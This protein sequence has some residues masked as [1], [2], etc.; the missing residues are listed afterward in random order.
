MFHW[1]CFVWFH[2]LLMLFCLISC[3]TN[4]VL[5]Y[6]MFH[7]CCFVWFHVSLVLF[8][9]ISCFTGVVLFDFMFYWCIY[10]SLVL[11]CLH[12]FHW[13]WFF[14]C[15]ASCVLLVL[16]ICSTGV[17][18]FAAIASILHLFCFVCC[19]SSLMLFGFMFNSLVFFLLHMCCI[20]HSN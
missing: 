19:N 13:H 3:F 18:L 14:L 8:C 9:L 17:V 20:V 10:V 12:L 7:W 2:V 15:Y 16:C 11:F 1:W 5:I 6:F 4:V